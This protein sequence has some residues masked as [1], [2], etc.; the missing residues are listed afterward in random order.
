MYFRNL[1]YVKGDTAVVNQKWMSISWLRL[2]F[3]FLL[4]T[5]WQVAV[6]S[7]A[8]VEPDTNRIYLV[9]MGPGDPDLA[10]IRALK[11]VEAADLIICHEGMKQRFAN[12]LK[13]KETVSP[14]KDV[15]IWHGY[16]KE[17]SDFQGKEL[18][19]FLASE[20]AREQI[21]SKARRAVKEGKTVAVIDTADPLIYGPWGW[22]LEE[23]ADLGPTVVPGLSSFNAANAALKKGVT[24]GRHTKSVILTMPDL[25][26]MPKNDTIEKLAQHQATMVIFMP[27]VLGT[28]LKDLVA[29]LSGY[30]RPDTPIALVVSAGYKEKERVIRGTLENIVDKVGSETLPFEHLVYVGDFLEHEMK[31]GK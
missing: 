3:L 14:P 26:D 28:K 16:G 17:A 25:A 1:S 15:W 22:I 19:K 29:K 30:Y 20:K 23:L 6:T 21:I 4:V 10:T 2:A 27:S 12:E 13:S 9:G 5:C 7:F 11:I 31:T 24:S 18:E 8:S